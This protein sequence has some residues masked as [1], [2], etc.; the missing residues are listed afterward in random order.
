MSQLTTSR[1]VCDT[2]NSRDLSGPCYIHAQTRLTSADTGLSS[3]MDELV[4]HFRGEV[5]RVAI[6]GVNGEDQ[7]VLYVPLAALKKYWT[8]T[9]VND[10]LNCPTSPIAENPRVI[11][12]SYLQIFS[13]LVYNGHFDRISWFFRSNPK[14]LDDHNLPFNAQVFERTSDWSNS[15]LEHQW[16]FC[17]AEFAERRYHKRIFDSKVILPVT[18]SGD[19]RA[20]RIGPDGATLRKYQLNSH[21][22]SIA[23]KVSGPQPAD[24][25]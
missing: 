12:E 6:S 10:I 25:I 1:Y 17:P 4:D 15:F 19:I 20:R 5:E 22:N 2:Y 16:M 7:V 23:P 21:S 8:E 3:P 9:R 14:N 24:D 18:Y 11:I 13:T